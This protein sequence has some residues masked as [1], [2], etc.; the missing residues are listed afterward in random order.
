M[1]DIRAALPGVSDQTI[2]VVL[3][4]LRREELLTSDGVGRSASWRRRR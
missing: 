2:R 1:A 3:D 4:R